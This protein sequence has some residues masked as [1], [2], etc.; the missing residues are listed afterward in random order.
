MN[1]VDTK[2]T[3]IDRNGT[4]QVKPGLALW[5]FGCGLA[6]ESYMTWTKHKMRTQSQTLLDA[7]EFFEILIL[8]VH[9]KSEYKVPNLNK[10]MGPPLAF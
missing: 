4:S 6:G 10:I 8:I 1:S 5:L 7:R 9:D 3:K 2:S